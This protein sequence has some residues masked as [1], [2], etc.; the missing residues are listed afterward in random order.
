MVDLSDK[1][2]RQLDQ[3]YLKGPHSFDPRM[4]SLLVDLTR[5]PGQ[6]RVMIGKA[7][8]HGV[9]KRGIDAVYNGTIEAVDVR[10]R[11]GDFG[12][13]VYVF[14]PKEHQIEAVRHIKNLR[15]KLGNYFPS[16]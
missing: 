12:R 3:I 2:K 10:V 9:K 11:S 14:V 16:S 4:T 8:T 7:F 1:L 15:G 13:Q 5:T 6:R